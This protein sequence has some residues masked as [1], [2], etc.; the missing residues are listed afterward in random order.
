MIFDYYFYRVLVIIFC[1][2]VFYTFRIQALCRVLIGYDFRLLFLFISTTR[3]R[4]S[5]LNFFNPPDTKLRKLKIEG[6][7]LV[8]GMNKNYNG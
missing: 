8:R 4:A 6:V 7:I 2:Y 1:K 5:T 3:M